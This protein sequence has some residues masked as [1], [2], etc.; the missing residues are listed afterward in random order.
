MKK[1]ILFTALIILIPFFV[2]QI[3][4]RTEEIKFEFITNKTIKVKDEKTGNILEIPFEDYV[5]GV[6]SGEMPTEFELEA[7][8]AQAVASRSYALYHMNGNEYDVTNTTSNQVYLTDEEL[9][10]K[11]KS[12]YVENINKVKEAILETKGEYL[13]YNGETINA[14]FF[15]TSVGKT[16]N[17]EEVFVSKLPYLRSV[18]S[19][20]DTSSPV[21]TDTVTINLKD[22]Y[23]KLDLEYKDKIEIEVLEKTSTGRTKKLKINGIELKGRDVSSKLQIRSNYF[24]IKQNNDQVIITTKGFGHGVGLSQYGANGMAKE[25]YNYKDILK[26]YYEGTEIQKM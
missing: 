9:K 3:F 21:F 20:W 14:M 4:V 13:T 2:T 15:S 25:G 16:E 11:W 6:V 12:K 23:Q 5:K 17:S 24:E 18:S 10:E 1:L 8:K 7:L 22:F 26:H 19:E